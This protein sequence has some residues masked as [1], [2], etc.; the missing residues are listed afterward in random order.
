MRRKIAHGL[1]RTARA[2]ALL[3]LSTRIGKSA[4]SAI[5]AKESQQRPIAGMERD[6][7]PSMVQAALSAATF[8]FPA[9]AYH[10][11]RKERHK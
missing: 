11:Y 5:P 9:V 2:A 4:G 7:L 6:I 3:Q 1:F 8:S 10:A